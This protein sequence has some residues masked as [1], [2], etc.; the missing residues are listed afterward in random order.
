[1]KEPRVWITAAAFLL[2][3]L[4]TRV[5]ELGVKP[6]HHDESLYA[7]EAWRYAKTGAYQ[8]N[9]MLH[10]PFEFHFHAALL[11]FLPA[12]DFTGRLPV[13]IF[14]ILF[15]L[16]GMLLL[17]RRGGAAMVAW[18]ALCALSPVMCFFS[19]FLGMDIV[20]VGLAAAFLYF[21]LE[22]LRT[23]RIGYAYGGT[24]ILAFMISTKLNWLFYAFSF[25]T[26]AA[27]WWFFQKENRNE[28]LREETRKALGFVKANWVDFAYC[29]GLFLVIYAGLYSSLGANREF[30]KEST[31]LKMVRYWIAQHEMQR[32]KGPF[33]YYVP[34]LLIYE[35][36]LLI[37]IA[38]ATLRA[39]Y[40]KPRRKKLAFRL[41]MS[42]LLIWGA[43]AVNWS[44]LGP[45]LGAVFHLEEPWHPALLTLELSAWWILVTY[46]FE[47]EET[48]EAFLVH[49]GITSLLL[50]SYA[51]EKIPWLT[52]HILLPWFLYL[53]VVFSS[54]ISEL[55]ERPVRRALIGSA[56]IL[57]V[58]W[59]G[60]NV[61]RSSF[62]YRAD[63]RERLV[64]THSSW[65]MVRL[66]DQ[67]E[68]LSA[69]TG[70]GKDL[71]IEVVGDS[72]WPLYWYLRDYHRWFYLEVDPKTA[73]WVVVTDWTKK[74]PVAQMLG[75]AYV[76]ERYKLREWWLYETQKAS[77]TDIIGYYFT[78]KPFS[79]LGSQDIAVFV[80]RD[81]LPLWQ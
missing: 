27:V 43:C 11:K 66:V 45:P 49:W 26:F 19:R 16:L 55:I 38:W 37:G 14:G 67:I 77:M 10:G 3:L 57:T 51:G 50:Y 72:A 76:Q 33:H 6:Y 1:M 62:A 13:M 65:D 8:F 21:L 28:R 9:P 58:G 41:L 36:P 44:W 47:R 39:A 4:V 69:A 31:I 30:W 5:T 79:V 7:V 74:D 61:I 48:F 42:T 70:E 56:L 40:S 53:A 34:L 2:F 68:H 29:A 80:R 20:M 15:P 24:V 64:Y 63:P 71:K 12:N 73:P 17:R 75:D 54:V 25:V 22:F 81:A 18:L 23:Q 32:I 78:R 60:F 52:T 46:H 35:L 59:Q